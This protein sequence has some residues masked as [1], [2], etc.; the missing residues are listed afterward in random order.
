M[1]EA[2]YEY[3]LQVGDLTEL[4]Y[5]QHYDSPIGPE[6]VVPARHWVYSLG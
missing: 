1:S 4:I 2:R 6:K 5:S 3:Y